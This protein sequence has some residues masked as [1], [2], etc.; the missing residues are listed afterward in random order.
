[1]VVG[2]GCGCGP[3][4]SSRVEGVGED[5]RW[6]DEHGRGVV[7]P[8]RPVEYLGRCSDGGRQRSTDGLRSFFRRRWLQDRLDRVEKRDAGIT[9]EGMDGIGIGSA[10]QRSASAA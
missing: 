10:A 6:E 7:E 2:A 1:M 3:V 9:R 4:E 8:E 5:A